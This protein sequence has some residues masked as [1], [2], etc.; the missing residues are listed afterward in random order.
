LREFER[1]TQTYFKKYLLKIK[2]ISNLLHLTKNKFD[3]YILIVI[4]KLYMSSTQ[5]LK[6]IA[7]NQFNKEFT[8]LVKKLTDNKHIIKQEVETWTTNP[9][10]TRGTIPSPTFVALCEEANIPKHAE[11]VHPSL[12]ENWKKNSII[13]DEPLCS[14]T[15]KNVVYLM[16]YSMMELNVLVMTENE[17]LEKLDSGELTIFFTISPQANMF[18]VNYKIDRKFVTK[19]TNTSYILEKTNLK[20]GKIVS[21][22]YYSNKYVPPNEFYRLTSRDFTNEYCGWISPYG[23]FDTFNKNYNNAKENKINTLVVRVM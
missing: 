21:Y 14:A 2:D 19:I 6:I 9:K 5:N 13:L 18:F 22:P 11:T 12:P 17:I 4:L 16:P 8:E 23:N 3:S 7:M 15:E 1:K 10:E 20:D